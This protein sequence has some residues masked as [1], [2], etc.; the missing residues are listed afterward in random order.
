MPITLLIALSIIPTMTLNRENY[1]IRQ[2]YPL[3]IK[4]IAALEIL[5][6]KHKRLSQLSTDHNVYILN[7]I[8]NHNVVIARLYIP[9]NNPAAT[10]VT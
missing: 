1:I 2:I 7:N 8:G 3:E 6:E 4:Q 9:D 5:N 10:I